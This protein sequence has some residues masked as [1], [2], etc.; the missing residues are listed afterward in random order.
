VGR[1]IEFSEGDVICRNE[2]VGSDFYIV[3]DGIV[4]CSKDSMTE[5]EA[6]GRGRAVYFESMPSCLSLRETHIQEENEEDKSF[7]SG[8]DNLLSK[9]AA[10]VASSSELETSNNNNN[11]NNPSTS[12][13]DQ[14]QQQHQS[15]TVHDKAVIKSGGYRLKAGDWFGEESFVLQPYVFN[16]VA[17]SAV[18]LLAFNRE[19]FENVVGSLKEIVDRKADEKLLMSLPMLDDTPPD[20]VF[21][22]DAFFFM[23]I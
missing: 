10:A 6:G 9:I 8:D 21:F 20:K 15:R 22:F 4:N 16:V 19:T 13:N 17:D 5:E 3:L 14:A 11:N 2:E 1:T 7:A 18:R 12:N 23:H